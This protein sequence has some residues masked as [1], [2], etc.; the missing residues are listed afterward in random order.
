MAI[1]KQSSGHKRSWFDRLAQLVCITAILT[2]TAA[3]IAGILGRRLDTLIIAQQAAVKAEQH[4]Q[5]E[6]L[7]TALQAAKSKWH[8]KQAGLEKALQSA[9][10]KI[11][12]TQSNNTKIREQL[13]ALQ[14][15]LAVLKKSGNTQVAEAVGSVK[16][17]PVKATEQGA[18]TTPAAA[19]L[20]EIVKPAG[21]ASTAVTPA[22]GHMATDVATDVAA[23]ES[24]AKQNASTMVPPQSSLLAVPEA[25]PAATE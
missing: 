17:A 12:A 24:V 8:Q 20:P 14:K 22:T 23:A 16:N 10:L 19:T 21:T 6:T 5:D 18:A 2:L 9:K 1:F 25:E 11:K 3:A 13:V 15:K 7:S 4:Q